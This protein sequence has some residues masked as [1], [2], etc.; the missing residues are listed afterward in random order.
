MSFHRSNLFND[1]LNLNFW[2]TML[3]WTSF[4]SYLIKIINAIDI[5]SLSHYLIFHFICNE[6]NEHTCYTVLFSNYH[7]IL[8]I[9]IKTLCLMIIDTIE[10]NRDIR[11]NNR[12]YICNT[13]SLFKQVLYLIMSFRT[14]YC[15]NFQYSCTFSSWFWK[16]YGASPLFYIPYILHTTTMVINY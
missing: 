15:M 11:F 14:E 6:F 1:N 9:V 12:R 5:P 4:I 7:K 10:W 2:R 16:L 13:W 8:F 3:I